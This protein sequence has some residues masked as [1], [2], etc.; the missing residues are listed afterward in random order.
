MNLTTEEAV[1]LRW[2]RSMIAAMVRWLVNFEYPPKEKAPLLGYLE[3]A[4][5]AIDNILR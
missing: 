3:M 2:M 1:K 5:K 4:L